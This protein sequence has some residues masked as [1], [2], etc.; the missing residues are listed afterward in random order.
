[1]SV[2]KEYLEIR[3][4]TCVFHNWVRDAQG[5][6]VSDTVCGEPAVAVYISDDDEPKGRYV[7]AQHATEAE[8]NGDGPLFWQRS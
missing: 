5:N 6:T 3:K 8:L 7:C 4:P 1:M 2:V